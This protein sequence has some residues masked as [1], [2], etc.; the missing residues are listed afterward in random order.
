[1]AF[2]FRV[3]KRLWNTFIMMVMINLIIYCVCL[4]CH[5]FSKS[6]YYLLFN[7][8]QQTIHRQ[9]KQV[10]LFLLEIMKLRSSEIKYSLEVMP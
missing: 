8:I 10:L 3:V 9:L 2:V 1:M 4:M 6:Y 7:F 5:M